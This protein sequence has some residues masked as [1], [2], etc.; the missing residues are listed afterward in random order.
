MGKPCLESNILDVIEDFDSDFGFPQV[1][2]YAIKGVIAD[3]LYRIYDERGVH[4]LARTR[5]GEKGVL[6]YLQILNWMKVDVVK[7]G[8]GEIFALHNKPFYAGGINPKAQRAAKVM[9]DALK[10]PSLILEGDTI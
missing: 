2:V 6:F 10:V 1:E 8:I 3:K 7:R 9:Y 4:A 5:E